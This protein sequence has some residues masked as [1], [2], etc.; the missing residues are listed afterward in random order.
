MMGLILGRYVSIYGALLLLCVFLLDHNRIVFRTLDHLNSEMMYLNHSVMGQAPF[1]QR[2]LRAA[3]R[4]YSCIIK[5][6]DQAPI[7]YN[8]MGWCYVA[9]DEPELAHKMFER[10]YQQKKDAF[11]INYNLGVLAYEQK[12][13]QSAISYF[14][15]N[16][17][18][19]CNDIFQRGGKLTS[20]NQQNEY[21]PVDPDNMPLMLQKAY[22]DGYLYLMSSYAARND[23]H[24]LLRAAVIGAG[25]VPDKQ[26]VFYYLAALAC[27]EL[28]AYEKGVTFLKDSLRANPNFSPSKVYLAEIMLQFEM[29]QKELDLSKLPDIQT[30]IF[31][32]KPYQKKTLFFYIVDEGIYYK[33]KRFE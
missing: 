12:D 11:G 16:V 22:V 3:L 20:I 4:Y 25:K 9:L 14:K 31:S 29:Q 30:D 1:Q 24:S 32:F 33:M 6:F 21:L 7:S 15:G 18:L 26:E 23:F 5:I 17:D 8:N 2:R 19:R 10:A 27:L 13:Y 28:K